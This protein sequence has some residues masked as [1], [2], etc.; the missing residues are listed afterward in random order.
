MNSKTV[1]D[2][3]FKATAEPIYK[4]VNLIQTA[5]YTIVL[6][7]PKPTR[8]NSYIVTITNDDTSK[9][10]AVF[11][12]KHI[13]NRTIPGKGFVYDGLRQKYDSSGQIFRER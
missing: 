1:H 9:E 8:Y 13:A 2:T 5:P 10:S 7:S 11:M 12:P 6:V 3:E 4:L